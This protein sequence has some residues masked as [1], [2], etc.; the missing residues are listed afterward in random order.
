MVSQ[1]ERIARQVL[2]AAMELGE[3]SVACTV[4]QGHVVLEGVVSS[5][6]HAYQ[7]EATTRSIAGVSSVENELAI[8][9]FAASVDSVIE[10]VDLV[11]DFTSEVSADDAMEAASEA[12]PYFPAIDPVVKPDRSTDGIEMVGGFA[13]SADEPDAATANLPGRP[14]GDDELREAVLAALHADAATTDLVLEVEAQ[15]GV[16]FLRGIVPSLDDADLAESVA[17]RVPGVEEVQDELE[18]QGL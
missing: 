4:E 16:V 17:A 9:G 10:G 11:P 3:M 18:I 8:E 15:D 5:D 12:E 2:Q 14:R 13:R 6:E 7:L 1:D